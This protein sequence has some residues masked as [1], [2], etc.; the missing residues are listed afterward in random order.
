MSHSSAKGGETLRGLSVRLTWPFL[1]ALNAGRRD[2]F[3]LDPKLEEDVMA[4]TDAHIIVQE[5]GVLIPNELFGQDAQVIEEL[6]QAGVLTETQN[7]FAQPSKDRGGEFKLMRR[8]PLIDLSRELR[9][10]KAHGHKYIGQWVA[11][12]GDRLL[13][14][15]TNAREVAEAAR[16][17]GVAIPFITQVDPPEEFP[18]GGW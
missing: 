16:A 2:N 10:L 9:W 14:H 3:G 13:G 15:G 12:D 5:H 1:I 4:E 11:L 18:F 17:A 8:V 7:G 6:K